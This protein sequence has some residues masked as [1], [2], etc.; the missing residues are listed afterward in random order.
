MNR[1]TRMFIPARRIAAALLAVGVIALSMATVNG[2]QTAPKAAEW[3]G[4]QDVFGFPG[5]LLP[6][7]VIRFNMPRNDLHVTIAGTEIK[8]GLALGAWAA[9]HPVG[10]NDAMVMGDLVLTDD[11]VAPVLKE[12]NAAE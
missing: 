8:P 9:F 10:A 6:D 7:N 2:L 3:K 4:A 1:A 11:E 12:M 5:D